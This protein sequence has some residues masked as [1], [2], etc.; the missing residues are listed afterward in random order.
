MIN[1]GFITFVVMFALVVIV[2]SIGM[3]ISASY[4]KQLKDNV[5]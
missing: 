5:A 2:M 3:A 4:W 1:V